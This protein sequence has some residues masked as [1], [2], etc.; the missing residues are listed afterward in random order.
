MRCLPLLLLTLAACGSD[1]TPTSPLLLAKGGVPA[2]WIHTEEPVLELAD[3]PPGW[4]CIRQTIEP[5]AWQPT[6]WPEVQSTPIRVPGESRDRA[7]GG[8]HELFGPLGAINQLPIDRQL[9]DLDGLEDD[10]F[11]VFADQLMLLD[12]DGSLA[13]ETLEYRGWIGSGSAQQGR[14]SLH[15]ATGDGFVLLP[16]QRLDLDLPPVGEQPG[17]TLLFSSLAHGGPS[18]GTA[19]TLE[20]QLD[21]ERVWAEAIPHELLG[22]PTPWRVEL[23]TFQ[24]GLLSLRAIDGHAPLAVFAPTLSAARPTPDPTEPARPDLVLFLADTFR[25]D[26]L[27]AYGG[28][29]RLTPHMNAFA[30]D[31]LVFA[32]AHAAASWT[33]PSQATML[34]GLHPHQHATLNQDRALA[35]EVATLAEHLAAA[36]YRTVAVTDGLFVSQRYGLDAGFEVFLEE[37]GGKGFT[38]KTIDR[39]R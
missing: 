16:G 15:G 24:G 34:S 30:D 33:L 4:L 19:T 35:P 23:P 25:A 9:M 37:T 8:P 17:A 31:A 21:G 27:A 38:T 2:G 11:L 36:G 20:L 12:R 18:A 3:A 28:D 7:G 32:R 6:I 14:I 26:N 1:S 39:L 5:G 10:S 13:G 22:P 29:P